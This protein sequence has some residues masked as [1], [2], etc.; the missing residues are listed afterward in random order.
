M[1]DYG[2][3]CP[4][5]VATSV[6]CER[7]TLQIIRELFLGSTRYSEIQKFIPNISPS[8]LRNRL[9]FL[10]EQGV[11]LR[12]KSAVQGHPEY[13]L[14]P[15]GKA[16]GPVLT[17]IGRWGMQYANAGMTDKQ[18]TASGLMRDIAGALKVDALPS[19]KTVIQFKLT[20]IDN[21]EK[22]FINVEDGI[23]SS[24]AQDLGFEPDVY[25]T[26]TLR[27]MTRIWYGE[28]GLKQA[29]RDQQMTV[30]AAPLYLDSLESWFGISEFAGGDPRFEAP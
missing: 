18:N 12:K 8:L 14:T 10:E 11:I 7:W 27:A 20:D 25:F 4:V 24:C 3:A 9:R 22:L 23:A 13:H 1:Y 29:L 6:L 15:A 5:S 21:G 28:L 30:V 2:E 17:E 19:G 16:L 26:S